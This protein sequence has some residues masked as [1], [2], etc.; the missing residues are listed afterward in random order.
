MHVLCVCIYS[1]V[2]L[3]W[4]VKYRNANIQDNLAKLAKD[5]NIAKDANLANNVPRDILL[6]IPVFIQ[7]DFTPP[8]L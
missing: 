3:I 8:P 7:I 2:L 4:E 6:N 1:Y 5:A